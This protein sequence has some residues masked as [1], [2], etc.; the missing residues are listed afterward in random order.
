[1]SLK[2]GN[3]LNRR[4]RLR[5]FSLPFQDVHGTSVY[6][7]PAT[8]QC[9]SFY[10]RTTLPNTFGDKSFN[11]AKSRMH[12]FF[13]L[14]YTLCSEDLIPFLCSVFLPR[15]NPGINTQ[16]LPCPSVCE[17][18]T[19]SCSYAINRLNLPW[20]TEMMC[21]KSDNGPPC[22][23]KYPVVKSVLHCLVFFHIDTRGF[24]AS[25]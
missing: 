11:N 25:E 19:K 5:Y 23:G 16:Q 14:V 17:Q 18:I 22:F 1:M 9:Y 12:S 21:A 24:Y 6:D 15:F 13:P 4:R 7:I 8:D 3:Y 2:L 10:R 20:P